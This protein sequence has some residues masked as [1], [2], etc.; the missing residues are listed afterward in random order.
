M[1]KSL[2][3]VGVVVILGLVVLWQ[4]SGTGL[5]PPAA[6]VPPAS[7]PESAAAP[8]AIRPPDQLIAAA[9]G[10]DAKEAAA[11]Y[12]ALEQIGQCPYLGDSPETPIGMLAAAYGTA[13]SDNARVRD[14]IRLLL[15]QG[16]DINQYSAV[17]LTPLHNA[18][19]FRQPE[20]LRFLL[21]L[22]ADDKLRVIHVPGNTQGR[23]IAN[24]DAYGLAMALRKKTPEDVALAE[25]AGQLGS[26]G[27]NKK[28]Q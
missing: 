24:L 16:C 17:G 25:I 20:L 3:A 28:D 4:R 10:A 26:S 2:I 15:Q 23:S 12:R 8:A 7:P 5:P 22:G 18:V 27:N 1:H 13:T 11:A 9:A 19:L 14:A 21:E 6:T